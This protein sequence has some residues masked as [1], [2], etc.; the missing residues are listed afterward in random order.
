MTREKQ[1]QARTQHAFR[2]TGVKPFGSYPKKR[3]PKKGRDKAYSGLKRML[4]Q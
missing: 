1:E 2:M 4:R 3:K